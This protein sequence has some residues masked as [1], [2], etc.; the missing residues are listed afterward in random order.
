MGK[1]CKNFKRYCILTKNGISKLYLGNCKHYCKT[2]DIFKIKDCDKFECKPN[3]DE[4]KE[5]EDIIELIRK[6]KY[7]LDYLKLYLKNK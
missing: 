6:I 7:R 4:I 1:D 5:K 3:E 2:I